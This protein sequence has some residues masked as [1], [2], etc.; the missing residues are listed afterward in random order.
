MSESIHPQKNINNISSTEFV[1]EYLQ[2]PP[3]K[4]DAKAIDVAGRYLKLAAL[5]WA[6]EILSSPGIHN[7]DDK[8]ARVETMLRAARHMRRIDNHDGDPIPSIQQANGSKT[9]LVTRLIE[10]MGRDMVIQADEHDDPN[11][12]SKTNKA[13]REAREKI[14]VVAR[15]VIREG[16]IIA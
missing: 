13:I 14:K 8:I 10:V 12:R 16:E 6:K 3:D 11:S 5:E 2:S 9:H 4:R 1:R 7:D 15:Q